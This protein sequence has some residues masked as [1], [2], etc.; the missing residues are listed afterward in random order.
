VEILEVYTTHTNMICMLGPTP[1]DCVGAAWDHGFEMCECTSN[2]E[3]RWL[4]ALESYKAPNH[5]FSEN[6][7][8]PVV[9]IHNPWSTNTFEKVK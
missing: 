9:L 7:K 5:G 3:G 4:P 6:T 1:L 2:Y 8:H